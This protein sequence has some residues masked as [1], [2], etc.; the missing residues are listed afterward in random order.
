MHTN[1]SATELSYEVINGI[2]VILDMRHT[3]PKNVGLI[4]P[5]P[6]DR[7]WHFCPSVKSGIFFGCLRS[8]I[9]KKFR[10][11]E[12]AWQWTENYFSHFKETRK[13]T[14]FNPMIR[15]VAHAPTLFYLLRDYQLQL[16]FIKIMLGVGAGLYV[17]QSDNRSIQVGFVVL[18]TVLGLTV[19]TDLGL[20]IHKWRSQR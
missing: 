8:E 11:A 5:K 4:K 3:P 20:F 13:Y 17:F 10:T 16:I 9:P 2:W 15:W 12:R 6:F 7:G 1:N 18:A 14:L 19:L